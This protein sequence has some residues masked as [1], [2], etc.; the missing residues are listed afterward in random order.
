[1]PVANL[2]RA[3]TYFSLKAGLHLLGRRTQ[4]NLV[5]IHVVRLLNRVDNGAGNRIGVDGDFVELF[6]RFSSIGVGNGACL[7]EAQ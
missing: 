7:L 5:D 2:I 3:R 1:M 4:D 6:R